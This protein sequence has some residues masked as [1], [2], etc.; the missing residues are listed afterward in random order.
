VARQ[1][2][3]ILGLVAF[4]TVVVRGIAGG[5]GA[6][7]TILTAVLSMFAFAAIG[8]IAGTIAEGIVR[9]AITAKMLAEVEGR[10][11]K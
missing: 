6:H 7:G 3:G 2:A 9:D 5:D 10:E 8:S 11:T 1:Y 4:V